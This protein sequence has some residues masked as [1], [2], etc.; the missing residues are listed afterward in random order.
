MDDLE[1]TCTGKVQ[2]FALAAWGGG[3]GGR[4]NS[5]YYFKI[6]IAGSVCMYVV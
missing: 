6:S 5:L 2:H 3:G 1:T 4:E